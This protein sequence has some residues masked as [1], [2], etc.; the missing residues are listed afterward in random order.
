MEDGLLRKF[1]CG[2]WLA[3]CAGMAPAAG[4]SGEIVIGQ[5]APLTGTIAGTG[6]E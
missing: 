3:L 6:Q 4:P 5:V 2:A 1:A